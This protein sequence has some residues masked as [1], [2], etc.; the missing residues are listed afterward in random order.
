MRG[1]EYVCFVNGQLVAV[2]HDDALTAGQVSF[3]LSDNT[4]TGH[5][6]S[7]AVYPAV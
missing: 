2:V 6:S 5:Y 4:T 1:S 3:W 7:F